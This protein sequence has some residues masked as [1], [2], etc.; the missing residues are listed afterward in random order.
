MSGLSIQPDKYFEKK[1]TA[2]LT[3]M[4]CPPRITTQSPATTPSA[5]TPPPTSATSPA[6]SASST[7]VPL[8]PRSLPH[9]TQVQH[10]QSPRRR[11]R[12]QERLQEH[13]EQDGVRGGQLP[14][15]AADRGAE[16]TQQGWGGT[17]QE[18]GGD[19]GAEE[20][21]QLAADW[22]SEAE[23]GAEDR[24]GSQR[25]CFKVR[26]K[27]TAIQ[28]LRTQQRTQRQQISARPQEEGIRRRNR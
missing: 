17:Q 14:Q 13:R 21:D 18:H 6:P 4:T 12:H 5:G 24:R 11:L 26:N 25:E 16:Q 23:G 19:R 2:A 15:P 1:C 22:E 8:P 10:H 3:Q 20:E 7:T 27:R 9:R 28:T